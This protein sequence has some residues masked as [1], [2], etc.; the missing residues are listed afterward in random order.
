MT[1]VDDAGER[2]SAAYALGT[3]DALERWA[4]TGRPG[5]LL[6]R[7][8]LDGTWD[9][10][11]A[12]GVFSRDLVDNTS[13]LVAQ[14]AG[15]Q[16]EAFLDTFEPERYREN[17]LVLV[18]LGQIDDPRATK[19]LARVAGSP[20]AWIRMDVAIGLG[21]RASATATATLV[22]LL[23]DAEYLVRYHA[24]ESLAKIGDASALAALRAFVPDSPREAELADQAIRSIQERAGG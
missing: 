4:A 20:S 14:I 23:G 12:P 11:P 5:V 16:P 21:R 15:A 2:L 13:A 22:K 18:G 17:S 9:P 6:L 24:L 19:R 10:A 7:E 3:D 1:M 8:F